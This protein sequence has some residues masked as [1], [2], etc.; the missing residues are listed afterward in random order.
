M[1]AWLAARFSGL[2]VKLAAVGAVV[3]AVLLAALRLVAI[4]RGQEKA[5][6]SQRVAQAAQ[7]QRD[8]EN[9]IAGLGPDELRARASRWVRNDGNK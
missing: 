5:A 6:Q 4:G 7:A 8:R 1:T 9:E 2:W 3:L